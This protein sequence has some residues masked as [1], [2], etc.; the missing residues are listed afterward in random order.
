MPTLLDQDGFKFFFYAN[1]HD[2]RR[3]VK[4]AKDHNDEFERRWDEFFSR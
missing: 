1:E 2:P 4:I 3:A